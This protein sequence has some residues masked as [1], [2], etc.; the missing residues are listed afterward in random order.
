[1][2]G[3]HALPVKAMEIATAQVAPPTAAMAENAYRCSRRH[4]PSYDKAL[5]Q[6]Y[7]KVGHSGIV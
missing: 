2:N 3:D 6:S 4:P 5:E 7:L 1:L